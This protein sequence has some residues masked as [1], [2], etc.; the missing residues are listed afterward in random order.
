MIKVPLLPDDGSTRS[1]PRIFNVS[2]F[3]PT[4]GVV[5]RTPY[6]SARV[7]I[8]N[9]QAFGQY[10]KLRSDFLSS[11]LD[12][13]KVERVLRLLAETVSAETLSDDAQLIVYTTVADTL[14]FK[15]QSAVGSRALTSSSRD[16]LLSMFNSLASSDRE[17]TSGKAMW[18]KLL[19][20]TMFTLTNDWVC[21]TKAVYTQGN[22][23]VTVQR[24]NKSKM[25]GASFSSGE[26]SSFTFPNNLFV[27]SDTSCTDIQFV[28]LKNTQWFAGSDGVLSNKV[29]FV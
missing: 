5:L 24:N 19:E 16:H 17:D 14:N 15:D 6:H 28:N 4:G 7:F 21:P 20:K 27:S 25:N 1:Y 22:F 10:L 23:E 2:L 12:D 13:S 8:S 18:V 26:S 9:S 3:A 11:D 29:G